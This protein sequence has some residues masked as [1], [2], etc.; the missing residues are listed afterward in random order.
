MARAYQV[1]N[2]DSWSGFVDMVNSGRLKGWAFRGLASA[3]WPLLS[4][5][6]RHLHDYV[7]DRKRW[8]YQEARS[9]RIFRRKA[10]H[11]LASTSEL[12]NDLACLALMQHHGAPTRLLDFT[13]SE[14]V[15]AFFALER[16]V[17]DAAV[18]AINTPALYLGVRPRGRGGR[19][20]L[21]AQ[22]NPLDAGHFARYFLPNNR[23][24]I[25]FGE[26]R[27]MNQRL[28]AQSGTFVVPG[29]IDEPVESIISAYPRP[30]QLL[31]KIVLRGRSLREEG[32]RALYQMNIT[33]A[34]L[35]PDLEGLARSMAYE[36][37]I[38]WLDIQAS[39]DLNA[40]IQ[41]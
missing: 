27:R 21:P 20:A 31:G 12:D 3:D 40:L 38:A 29:V 10:H 26:P 13:K 36:L 6:S 1:V 23:R 32:M 17:G 14:Y 39:R 30:R 22:V 34:S 19:S 11:F 7:P 24:F 5:L 9:I 25:W 16:A 4:S 18:W 8:I 2:I 35:F 28:I 37:E 15:A 41:V 33:H